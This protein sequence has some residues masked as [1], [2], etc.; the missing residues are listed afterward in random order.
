LS[1]LPSALQV[2][3]PLVSSTMLGKIVPLF[4]RNGGFGT[5]T[6]GAQRMGLV[7]GQK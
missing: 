4:G 7:S 3:L 5:C 2:S 6:V 1:P